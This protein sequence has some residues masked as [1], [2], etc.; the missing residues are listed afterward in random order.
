MAVSNLLLQAL[1][2]DVYVHQMGGF[3]IEK[4]KE[5]FRLDERY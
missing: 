3:S 2:M 1:A 5:Y 4:V